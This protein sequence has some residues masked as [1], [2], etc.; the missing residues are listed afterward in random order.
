MDTIS[1]SRIQKYR[2][3]RYAYDLYYRQGLRPRVQSRAPQLGTMVHAGLEHAIKGAYRGAPDYIA[4]ATE[5]V[6]ASFSESVAAGGQLGASD[7][8]QL[9]EIK[10]TALGLATRAVEYL[11]LDQWETLC[12]PDGTPLIETEISADIPGVGK[13]IA[14]VDWVARDKRDGNIWLIDHKVRKAFLNEEQEETGTQFAIY[15][16]ILRSMGIDVKGSLTFQIKAK[17][18]AVPELTK[19]GTMS[20]AKISTDWETYRNAL[21]A[22]RLNVYDYLDMQEKL[23][24]VEFFRLTKM[25]RGEHEIETVWS[26]AVATAHE[27]ARTDLAMTRNLRSSFSCAQCSY[28]DYCLTELRGGD[29]N[30]LRQVRYRHKDEPA[31]PVFDLGSIVLVDDEQHT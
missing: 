11:Q 12:L 13:F 24:D 2:D 29:T 27:M 3:C 1:Y 26:E 5:G 21:L 9:E 17:L 23:A 14:F 30:F 8:E 19:K 31:Q 20:K 18:P 25:F 6:L 4:C 7:L 16:H 28:R 10:T 22:A 15:L